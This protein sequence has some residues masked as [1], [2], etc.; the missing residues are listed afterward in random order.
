[1]RVDIREPNECWPWLGSIMKSIGYGFL[2]TL[3]RKGKRRVVLAHR[4]ALS[5]RMDI[6][7]GKMALHECDYKICCNPLHLF[8]GTHLNNMADMYAKQRHTK[9][10]THGMHK[11]TEIDVIN[12]RLRA[13]SGENQGIIARNYKISRTTVHDVRFKSWQYL[14]VP[15]VHDSENT[16][17]RL[18]PIDQ[19]VG[20][21]GRC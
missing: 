17:N 8:P 21:G 12:I 20:Q 1:M 5:I 9:G 2:W 13:A 19:C 11:L 3:H 6:P 18:D 15:E 10:E 14:K 7:K 16:R 4:I